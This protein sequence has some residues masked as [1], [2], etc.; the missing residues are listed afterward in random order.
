MIDQSGDP[1]ELA[2]FPEVTH[3]YNPA[4]SGLAAAKNAAVQHASGDIVLFLDDDVELLPSCIETLLDAF[5]RRPNAAGMTCVV[6]N[7][8]QGTHWWDVHAWVFARG[9]FNAAQVRGGDLPELRRLQ[10]CALAAKRCL[11][12]AHPVDEN[13]IGYSYGE[14]WELSHRLREHG[15]L[16]LASESHVLHHVSAKNRY[17]A[18]Q[19]NRDRWDNFLYFYDHLHASQIGMNRFWRWWW[20]F[21]QSLLWL[22][23]GMGLPF[24]G[25]NSASA[26]PRSLSLKRP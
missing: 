25:L 24:S 15:A 21:G 20:M 5:E 12:Q 16:L 13:L 17:G 3:V 26:P 4:L 14:D 22:K 9:F 7:A 1:Y 11:L 19:L 23:D 8:V 10:G 18:R 2:A 6:A